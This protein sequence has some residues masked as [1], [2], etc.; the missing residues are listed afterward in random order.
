MKNLKYLVIVLLVTFIY[1]N[2]NSQVSL[3]VAA[4]GGI[5]IANANITPQPQVNVSSR[6]GLIIGGMLDIFFTP[7]IGI[8]TG[9]RYVMKG[10]EFPGTLNNGTAVQVT[11]KA[12]YLEFPVLFKVKFPL[13]EVKPYL[14][15]GPTLGLNL[16]SN[17]DYVGGGQQGSEDNSANTE[18]ID[19]GLLFGAGSDFKVA[20]KVSLFVQ[21]GYELGLSNV[22]KT[23]NQATTASTT[24]TYGLQFTGGVRFSL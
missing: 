22:A 13:T 10:F 9:M 7:Q 8:S 1:S 15:A 11:A 4:E 18:S 6:T 23:Q 20:N 12:N 19:F 17:L 3:Y 14:L 24:K 2:A 21:F 16:T 5:N